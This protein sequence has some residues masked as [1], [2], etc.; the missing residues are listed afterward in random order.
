MT[1]IQDKRAVR[2]RFMKTLYER[3]DGDRLKMVEI[4]D[5]ATDLALP[6]QTAKSIADYLEGEG[7]VT[8]PVAGNV[9][10]ISHAGVHE[11][12]EALADPHRETEHFAP[13]SFVSIYG[14]VV[15]SQIQSG[16][17]SSSQLQG[18]LSVHDQREDIVTFA[19]EF[20]RVLDCLDAENRAIAEANLLGLEAQMGLPAPNEGIVRE[21]L[22]TLRSI[23]EGVA[24]NAAFVGLV[25]LAHRLQL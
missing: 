11:V 24:G 13:I 2:L 6:P 8:F 23:V 5:I 17:R 25:E 12:E 16:T 10:S 1:D 20:K 9:V 14:P 21:S 19:D 18:G 22:R 3:T 4:G 7:L 15:G